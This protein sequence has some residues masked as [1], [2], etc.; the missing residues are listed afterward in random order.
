MPKKLWGVMNT[1]LVKAWVNIS[2][3]S[4]DVFSLPSM[5]MS[6]LPPL[7]RLWLFWFT[8]VTTRVLFFRIIAQPLPS[9]CLHLYH[10]KGLDRKVGF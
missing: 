4:S 9:T 1:V 8:F 2:N 7:F 3:P 6:S 5:N 10:G